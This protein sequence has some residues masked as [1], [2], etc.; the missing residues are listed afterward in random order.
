MGLENL[1]S[2]EFDPASV[3]DSCGSDLMFALL[4][5]KPSRLS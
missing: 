3:D 2:G 1:V 5:R 4:R